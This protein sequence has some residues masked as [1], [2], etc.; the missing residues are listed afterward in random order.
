LCNIVSDD[1]EEGF[2]IRRYWQ[3]LS[4][5]KKKKEKRE[6]G[7]ARITTKVDTRHRRDQKIKDGKGRKSLEKIEQQ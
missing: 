7:E 1:F 2:K 5:E 6:E 4:K 3:D